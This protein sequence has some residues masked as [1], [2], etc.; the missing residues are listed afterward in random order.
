M[1]KVCERE[2]SWRREAKNSTY[3]LAN[4]SSRSRMSEK[5]V[6]TSCCEGFGKHVSKI[7]RHRKYYGLL[8]IESFSRSELAKALLS[9]EL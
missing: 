2:W 9:D 4:G 1:E 3:N 8:C 7:A 6:G 5:L